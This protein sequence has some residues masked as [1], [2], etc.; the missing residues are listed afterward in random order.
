MAEEITLQDRI[1]QA[2]KNCKYTDWGYNGEDE[3]PIEC[4][5]EESLVKEIEAIIKHASN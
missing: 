3:Y 1:K 4:L 2:I 5:D